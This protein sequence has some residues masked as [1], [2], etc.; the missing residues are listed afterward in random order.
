MTFRFIHSS[1]L[2]LGRRFLSLPEPPDGNLRGRLMEARFDQIRR[3]AA[4]ARD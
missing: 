3:L 1:D 2:H 4:V